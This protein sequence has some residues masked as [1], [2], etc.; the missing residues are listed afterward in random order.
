MIITSISS[1]P[2]SN[3][4]VRDSLPSVKA[5][6]VTLRVIESVVPTIKLPVNDAPLISS[7]EIPV[8]VYGTFTPLTTFS[9]TNWITILSPSLTVVGPDKLKIGSLDVST[10][11]TSMSSSPLSN[12]KVRDSLPSVK[13]SSVT[14]RVTESVVPTTKLP[15]NGAPLISSDDTP[16]IVYGIF[17]P[18][19][20]FSVTNWITILSPSVTVVG[21]DKL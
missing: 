18:L 21:P 17:T 19:T 8:I 20:I 6:S 1:S 5:S 15:V 11:I 3:V 9:V 12:V 14:L 7:D 16:V 4:K 13:A 10:I 2:L